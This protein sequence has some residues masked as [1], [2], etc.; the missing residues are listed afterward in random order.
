[1]VINNCV[2]G[3]LDTYQPRESKP[4]NRPR[5]IHLFRRLGFS[6]SL[7]IIDNALLND[8]SFVVDQLFEEALNV[9]LADPPEWENKTQEEYTNFGE[10]SGLE[11]R[12]WRL[13]WI[14]EMAARGIREKMTL[15]WHNHFVTQVQNYRCPSWLYSYHNLLQKHVFGNF[16]TFVVEMGKNPA[17]LVYLNGVQNTRREPNENYARELYELFTLGRDNG[18]TQIDIEE[19][20]RALT[21]WNGFTSL[22]AP[23]TYLNFLHDNEEKTIFGRTGNWDYE[24]VHDILFEERGTE[25]AR[26]IC[27]KI[28]VHFVDPN[29]NEEVIEGLANT[30]IANNFEI[31]PVLK[32]LFKSEHFFD[33]AVIGVQF[34]SPYEY[35]LNF[36]NEGNFPYDRSVLEPIGYFAALLGQQ[37]FNPPDVAGWPGD[38]NW[39]NNNTITTRWETIDFYLFYLYENHPDSLVEIAKKLSNDSTDPAL[40]A[41]S[42]ADHFI[43]NGLSSP[44]LYQ[45][46]TETFKFEVPQNYF[47]EGLWNL[48]WET[49]PVQVTLLLQYL[50]RLPEFQLK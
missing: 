44:E 11:I 10:E 38:R 9:T 33:D 48:D 49:A 36:I 23:I 26:Y 40:V 30:F 42:I 8:P 18:Y 32:Q 2:T 21:G 45:G 7:D 25:I 15:F 13:Q 24:D 4:W 37:L 19:T 14:E 31:I 28:Y 3:T 6:G 35:F 22:C 29:A 41:Q 34:K 17:M 43:P 50:S 20:A 47:D 39:I 16:K 27:Q 1:M 46:A 5:A 12:A